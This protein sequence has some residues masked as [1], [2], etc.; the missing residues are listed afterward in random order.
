MTSQGNGEDESAE[1]NAKRENMF[2]SNSRVTIDQCLERIFEFG[3][4]CHVQITPRAT[5]PMILR[6]S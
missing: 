1:A 5:H 3:K 6:V 2:L 4:S